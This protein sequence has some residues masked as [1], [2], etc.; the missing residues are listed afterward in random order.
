LQALGW[1]AAIALGDNRDITVRLSDKEGAALEGAAVIAKLT[2]PVQDGY[3]FEIS[4]NDRGGGVYSAPAEFPL[5]G[6]W[7][8]RI[9]VTW[10]DTPY[11]SSNMV[12]VR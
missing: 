9:F 3:D 11:Q 8:V 10:Q 12:V 2:R 4:L 6:Q 5:P 7:N 1:H